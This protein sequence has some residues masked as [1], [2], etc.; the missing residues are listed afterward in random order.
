[1]IVAVCRSVSLCVAVCCSLLHTF[2]YT[3]VMQCV[4]VCCSVLQC[5]AG[6]LLILARTHTPT[7]QAPHGRAAL[8]CT[9]NHCNTLQHTA[10]H[11]TTLQHTATHCNT[12]QHTATRC[13][14][15]HHTATH[16]LRLTH[17][18]EELRCVA[19]VVDTEDTHAH[20]HIPAHTHTHTAPVSLY[21]G[22]N[23]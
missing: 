12:L 14:T 6:C 18:T 3:R 7:F 13:N 9:W 23:R 10:A 21:H 16:T 17:H 15:L 11:C 19:R 4:A 5:V 1:M 22:V 8:F 2:T 20:T